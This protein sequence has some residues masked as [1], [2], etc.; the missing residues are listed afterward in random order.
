M[1]IIL[2]TFRPSR[3]PGGGASNS[4]R[5]LNASNRKT[6]CS[7]LSKPSASRGTI[8]K[9]SYSSR[10]DS[11][12][13][14]KYRLT[15][16]PATEAVT[17]YKDTK[18]NYYNSNNDKTILKDFSVNPLRNSTDFVENSENNLS[19]SAKASQNY[20]NSSSI[21]SSDC[22]NTVNKTATSSQNESVV[23]VSSKRQKYLS[24]NFKESSQSRTG[25]AQPST[26]VSQPIVSRSATF[27][28]KARKPLLKPEDKNQITLPPSHSQ[29]SAANAMEYVKKLTTKDSLS[30][31]GLNINKEASPNQE[32]LTK[33]SN[34]FPNEQW[35]TK[36]NLNTASQSQS[37]S[38]EVE[39]SF[40][41]SFLYY[42][43]GFSKSSNICTFISIMRTHLNYLK[44][45]LFGLLVEIAKLQLKMLEMLI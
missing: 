45:F 15:V 35:R 3:I 14:E 30:S 37:L 25:L 7:S 42:A 5:L 43:I 28:L 41:I 39:V 26:K 17:D 11:S 23:G 18:R 27:I 12:A 40:V 6:A 22:L 29:L 44:C 4:S 24:N 34:I 9:V 33:S 20:I 31:S 8:G 1:L 10:T 38:S 21:K 16:K 36:T 19:S 2:F 13:T 32:V